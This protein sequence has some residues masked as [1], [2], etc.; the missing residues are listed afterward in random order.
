MS[1]IHNKIRCLKCNQVIESHHRHDFV[2]CACRD[3]EGRPNGVA[4]DGGKDYLRRCGNMEDYEEL[5]ESD[6]PKTELVEDDDGKKQ[7]E[8]GEDL[9]L[10]IDEPAEPPMKV[11]EEKLTPTEKVLKKQGETIALLR[12]TLAEYE[13]Q[14]ALIPRYRDAIRAARKLLNKNVLISPDDTLTRKAGGAGTQ[15][16]GHWIAIPRPEY[17]ELKWFLDSAGSEEEDADD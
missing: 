6:E 4:V 8:V 12:D 5:S 17:D 10:G 13:R 1:I 2:W 15:F 16:A 9:I 11:D 14:G 7:I 3:E